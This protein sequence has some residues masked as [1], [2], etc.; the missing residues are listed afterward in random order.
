LASFFEISASRSSSVSLGFPVAAAKLVEEHVVE[1][2]VGE[3]VQ[4]ADLELFLGDERPAVLPGGVGE[5]SAERGLQRPFVLDVLLMV[6]GEGLVVGL[7]RLVAGLEQGG[8]RHGTLGL[9]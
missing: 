1:R 9:S 5:E 8:L 7:D 4:L 2:A 6:G 3:D